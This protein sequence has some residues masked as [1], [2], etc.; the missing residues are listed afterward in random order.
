[1]KPIL[2]AECVVDCKDE[3][4]EGPVWCTRDRVLHWVDC[5]RKLLH[6]YSPRTKMHMQRELSGHIGSLAIRDKGGLLVALRTG[7]RI[8]D[9]ESEIETVLS[10][11]PI[12]FSRERFNDGKVDHAG[13]FWVGTIDRH[14]RSPIAG[15]YVVTADLAIVK[16]QSRVT[17]ANGIAWSQDSKTMYFC[18]SQ[19]GVVYAYDYDLSR[20]EIAHKKVFLDLSSDPYRPDGCTVDAFGYL[21]IAQ[22]HANRVARYDP[23]G[24]LSN[25]VH[26]AHARPS[27]VMFG[28]DELDTLYITTM[29]LGASPEELATEA[30]S[31]GLFAVAPDVCG[32]PEPR[33]AG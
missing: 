33:F 8:Y 3:L 16:K 10:S 30:N 25:V 7:L 5:M 18:D 2:R 1:M 26:V 22:P 24:K 29:R 31:G 15:L 12:D 9:P 20:G 4:G 11:E 17:L 21:W 14:L 28:G 19:P 13:R 32:L 27:S 23:V 6:T